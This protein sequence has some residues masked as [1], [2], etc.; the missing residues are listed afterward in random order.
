M[1][2]HESQIF[3]VNYF[4]FNC[5]VAPLNDVR[6]RRALALAIDQAQIARRVVQCELVASSFTPPGCAGYSAGRAPAFDVAEAQRLLAAAGFPEGRGFP[7][8]ELF[9]TTGPT[10]LAVMEAAQQMWRK[11]LGIDIAL[12]QQ[13]QKVVD[14]ALQGRRYQIALNSFIG[15]H[16]D[17]TALLV[18]FRSGDSNNLCGWASAEYD[19]LFGL[20]E[21]TADTAQRYELIRQAEALMLAETPVVPLYYKPARVLRLP[22]VKGWHDNLLDLHAL[23]FVWLEK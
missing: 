19:R 15:D 8:L 6:V 16:L 14:D 11:N 1:V 9:C 7:R 18:I 5:T 17:P 21:L 20:A 3:E 4:Q 10:S 22:A 13:E 23:K 2:L 12:V